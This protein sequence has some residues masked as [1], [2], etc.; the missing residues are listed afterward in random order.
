ML[1]INRPEKSCSKMDNK[2]AALQFLG[3]ARRARKL[4][5]G[6]DLVLAAI[7]SQKAK[8]VFVASDA[9]A[10]TTKKFIDKSNYY[11]VPVYNGYTKDELSTAIG[12][13]RSIIGVLDA[14]MAKKLVTLIHN[15]KGE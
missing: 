1:I 3:L 5:T 15:Q 2:Q 7:R 13:K 9:G 4:V 6:Q 11:H 12:Q 14:G 8:F 10:N